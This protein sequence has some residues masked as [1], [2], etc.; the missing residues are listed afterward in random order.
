MSTPR[1][2][3]QRSV[4]GRY[5]LLQFAACMPR[6]ASWLAKLVPCAQAMQ[7]VKFGSCL[8]LVSLAQAA[9]HLLGS[10]SVNLNLDTFKSWCGG[11]GWAGLGP[12]SVLSEEE[13]TGS[14]QAQ[15]ERRPNAWEPLLTASPCPVPSVIHGV[16]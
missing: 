7:A 9:A 3:R 15:D 10:D 16:P 11:L 5:S 14:L 1:L 4:L 8:P 12:M 6:R 2:R 13:G